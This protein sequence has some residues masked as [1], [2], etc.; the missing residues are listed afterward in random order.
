MGQVCSGAVVGAPGTCTGG[1]WQCLRLLYI[2]RGGHKLLDGARYSAAA[3]YGALA[4][5]HTPKSSILRFHHSPAF[6][7]LLSL[8]P[9][10]AI[11]RNLKVARLAAPGSLH[12]RAPTRAHP[13]ARTRP[14]A[15]ARAH[16]PARTRPRAP[17]RAH[18]PAAPA[19]S[20]YH[21]NPRLARGM[22]Y[23]R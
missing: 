17:A 23:C 9:L 11:G 1:G 16:P 20:C 5:F 15:P 21:R 3:L 19:R 18:P 13:P 22:E 2:I 12:P 7:F 14:R 6:R 10:R 8:L 4:L